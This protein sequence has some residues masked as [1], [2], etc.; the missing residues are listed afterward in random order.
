[1]NFR[2]QEFAGRPKLSYRAGPAS[3]PAL[4]LLHGVGRS[5]GDYAGLAAMLSRRWQVC[6]LDLR[7]HGG[8]ERADSYLVADY[9]PDVTDFVTRTYPIEPVTLL[10]HSLGAMVALAVAANRPEQVRALILEDPPF[11]T[12]GREIAGTTWKSL[13]AGMREVAR[14]SGTREQKVDQL[15]QVAI[16][17]GDGGTARPLGESRPRSSIE[18]SVQFLE[19]VDPEVFTPIIEG[20]WLDG[21]DHGAL[22]SRVQCPLLLLQGDPQAGAALT[23][24]EVLNALST[25]PRCQVSNFPAVGHMIHGECPERML[26]AM[27]KFILGLNSDPKQLPTSRPLAPAAWAAHGPPNPT[28]THH[29]SDQNL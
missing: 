16:T 27:D 6:C 24:A 21:F 23:D 25:A 28:S 2:L 20:R 11:H 4:L 10:G 26:E 15:A 7:G 17:S 9:V 14:S 22:F 13:F 18:A 5:S 12:M 1:V 8:S 3:G 29:H 19:T